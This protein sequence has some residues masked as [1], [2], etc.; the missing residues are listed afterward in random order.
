MWTARPLYASLLCFQQK[1]ARAGGDACIFVSA[2][3]F[4]LATVRLGKL[5]GSFPTLR[6]AAAKSVVMALIAAG[7]LGASALGQ[8]RRA[9]QGPR[10]P[11]ACLDSGH[12]EQP[13]RH[14]LWQPMHLCHFSRQRVQVKAPGK[15]ESVHEPVQTGP[16]A[17]RVPGQKRLGAGGRRWRA[18]SRWRR[19]GRVTRIPWP[20]APSCGRPWA[21]ARW[22]PSCRRRFVPVCARRES[23]CHLA[24]IWACSAAAHAS[25]GARA[26]PLPSP[27]CVRVR[28]ARPSVCA[29]V[30][31]L[32]SPEAA[33]A[34][35]ERWST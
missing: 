4:S 11:L 12:A 22:L 31:E 19:C 28:G 29:P 33:L 7:W 13:M 10:F 21:R 27:L 18:G 16:V 5:A 6:L 26:A 30:Q 9:V 14:L 34:A 35:R 24:A 17:Q 25:A 8:A 15:R 23:A 20:G 32:L 1:A 3:F 2:F